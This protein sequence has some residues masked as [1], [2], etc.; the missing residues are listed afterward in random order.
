[1]SENASGICLQY[2][3]DTSLYYDTTIKDL[4]TYVKQ[5]NDDLVS[6]KS[7]SSNTNLIFHSTQTKTL[8]FST[9][10]M[11][12]LQNLHGNLYV[13]KSGLIREDLW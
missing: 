8:H 3:D 13:Q 10:Q 2:A 1:M 7:R 9:K 12:R 6:I 11:S 4:D 5:V